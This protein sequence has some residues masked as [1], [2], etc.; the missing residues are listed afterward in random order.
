V[1]SIRINQNIKIH[2]PK[3]AIMDIFNNDY[4]TCNF[5]ACILI[6]GLCIITQL[7][8]RYLKWDNNI[9]ITI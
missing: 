5:T 3:Y 2:I 4:I 9:R 7:I 8:D 1:K 6:N